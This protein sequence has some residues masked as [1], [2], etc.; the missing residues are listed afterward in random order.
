M[1]DIQIDRDL[2]VVLA[3]G[4]RLSGD[5]YRPANAQPGPVLV[6]FYPYRT[7]DIIGSLFEGCRIRL[8]ERGYA[9]VFLDIAGTGA[10][11]GNFDPFDVQAETRA[12]VETIGWIANQEWCNGD[13]GAWGVSYGGLT[14]LAVAARRPA[15]L[16]AIVAVYAPTDLY[17]HSISYGGC[18]TMLGRYAWAAHMVALGLCP[19][20]RQDADG[21]WRRTWTD[22]LQRFADGQPPAL[23]WQAHPTRDEYWAGR[24]LDAT[25]IEVPTMIIGGWADGFKGAMLRAYGDVRGPKKLVMGPWLHVLPHLCDIER[26]DWV[27]A[28]ADWWDRHLRP[29]SAPGDGRE[30]PVLFFA[31][32]EGW[33]AASQWPLEGV[34][35][36]QL[37]LAGYRLE[38]ALPAQRGSRDYRCDPTVG[39]TGGMYDPFG[40]GNGRPEE[41]SSDDARSL[42]LTSDPLEESVLIA[43]SPEVDLCITRHSAA[44]VRLA[45]RLCVVGPDDN[46]TLITSGWSLL[47]AGEDPAGATANTI[48]LGPAAFTVEAGMRLR[49]S[50]ACADFPRIWPSSTNPEVTVSFGADAVSVLRMPTLRAADRRDKPATIAL[51]PAEP[52]DGWV[53]DGAPVYSTSHDK[54]MQEVAV[55]FGAREQLVAPSGADMKLEEKFT[56]RVQADRPDGAALLAQVDVA[57]RMPAGERVEVSVHSRSSRT[58]SVVEASVAID[59]A[60][61]LRQTW[62]R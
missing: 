49:L 14:A 16:R 46:S 34:T 45:V 43:G 9:S 12:Y 18:T 19:P 2:V 36:T 28:M 58:A 53:T 6:S 55:T 10:S 29:E 51:A 1:S 7:D 52:D 59:G 20:T 26:Y 48:I 50:V 62:T 41:Q 5:L 8:C 4:T 39:I 27:A 15:N 33:R 25:A 22:R 38:A 42:T 17:A 40:T 35:Q 30:E 47:P 21:Q 24:Q 32:N 61:L 44:E 57:I 60:S 13:I 11:E 31:E 3:D 56:A 23:T 37:F 54:V